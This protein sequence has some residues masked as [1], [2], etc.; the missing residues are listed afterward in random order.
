MSWKGVAGDRQRKKERKEMEKNLLLKLP[1]CC[2]CVL[3]SNRSYSCQQILDKWKC[4]IDRWSFGRLLT[5]WG[6]HLL[7]FSKIAVS[8]RISAAIPSCFLMLTCVDVNI[9]SCDCVPRCTTSRPS[10]YAPISSFDVRVKYLY[11]CRC[12]SYVFRRWNGIVGG[13]RE[14][15]HQGQNTIQIVDLRL[16]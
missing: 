4:Q 13:R 1:A 9:Y 7:V 5:A 8:G 10:P 14:S 12:V 11:L 6:N 15:R 16:L 2:C 3:I